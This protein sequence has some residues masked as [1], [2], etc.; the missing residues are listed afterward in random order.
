MVKNVK[1][2]LVRETKYSRGKTLKI[3]TE[4]QQ[5]EGPPVRASTTYNILI[6]AVTV[7]QRQRQHVIFSLF[8]IKADDKQFIE[9][10]A[11]CS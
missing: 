5:L 4:G 8:G 6:T 10:K 2:K 7:G 3:H 11:E 9:L 1:E